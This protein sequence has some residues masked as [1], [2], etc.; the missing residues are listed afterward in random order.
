MTEKLQARYTGE[1]AR[2]YDAKRENSPRY[3]AEEAAFADFVARV[4]PKTVVDCPFGTGRWLP[5]YRDLPGPVIAVDL[6]ADM[7]AE[8]RRK[9]GGARADLRWVTGSIFEH[10]FNQYARLKLDLAV[11][12]RF[13]NWVPAA[14]AAEAIARI[15]DAGSAFAIIGASVRPEDAPAIT[16]LGMR[17]RL[18]AANLPR[19]LRGAAPQYVHDESVV[20]DAFRRSGWTVVDRRPIFEKASRRNFFY[21]LKRGA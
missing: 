17:L 3:R 9:A 18:A 15:S 12:T 10:D 4:N 5:Y 14:R 19:R 20:L 11:C 7:L 1:G 21:L 16:R 8:A 13:V 2:D 6:S